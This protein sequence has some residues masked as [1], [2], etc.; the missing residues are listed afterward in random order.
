M[1][2]FDAIMLVLFVLFLCFMLTGMT[3][4]IL[5]KD[6]LRRKIKDKK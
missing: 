3:R 6:E 2:A 5:K 4:Q 1:S